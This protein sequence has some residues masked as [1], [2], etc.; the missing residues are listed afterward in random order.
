MDSVLKIGEAVR[1]RRQN[2]GLDLASAALLA[3]VGPRFLSELERGAKG[4][5][6]F[7][8]VIQVMTAFGLSLGMRIKK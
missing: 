4:T 8:Q 5:L 7:A 1:Q 2:M 6:Q 3:G